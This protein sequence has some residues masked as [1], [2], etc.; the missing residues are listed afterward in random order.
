MVWPWRLQPCRTRQGFDVHQHTIVFRWVQCYVPELG[1]LCCLH[2]KTIN[3]SYGVDETSFKVKSCWV[4]LYHTVDS[5][6]ITLVC[7]DGAPWKEAFSHSGGLA[8]RGQAMNFPIFQPVSTKNPL[9][10]SLQAFFLDTLGYHHI[11]KDPDETD[12]DRPEAWRMVVPVEGSR[13]FAVAYKRG[14]A[15]MQRREVS[16]LYSD[17][18][19]PHRDDSPTVLPALYGFTDG[20]RFVVFSADPARNRDDRFDLSE[21]SWRLRAVQEK[22]ERLHRERLEFQTRLGQKRPLVEFLFEGSPLSSDERF[23]RYVQWVRTGLMD[24]VLDDE[25]ALA[26]VLYF[27]IETPESH[28][29]GETRFATQD[30]YLKKS[31]E[32]LHLELRMR[33]GDA[34][35]G[36]VD[37]L[38]LRY[39]MVRFLESYHPEAMQGLLKSAAILQSGKGGPVAAVPFSDTELELARHL[40]EPLGI[41]VSQAKKKAGSRFLLSR[42]RGPCQ[43]SSLRDEGASRLGGY[44]YLADLGRAARAIE[45]VLLADPKSKGAKLLQDFLGRTGAPER[46]Q[47]DFRYE[48]S[49]APDAPGLL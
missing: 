14:L 20:A 2:L 25:Q 47:G 45:E 48:D 13:P 11:D 7:Y 26:S 27:L 16:R 46:A 34:V 40:T 49:Q 39:M 18:V 15:T 36:A 21:D 19:I 41:D 22:F 44:F 12:P 24:A 8:E 1:K 42:T 9:G 29:T 6:G 43:D 10:N 31:R 38:L 32:D 17:R 3:G 37:T 23:K 4:R 30:R 35:A 28:E 5:T 33:L